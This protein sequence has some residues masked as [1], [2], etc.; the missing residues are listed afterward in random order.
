MAFCFGAERIECQ[1]S[2]TALLSE[3]R[4]GDII[5]G[6]PR[7]R[8][9]SMPSLGCSSTTSVGKQHS[10]SD[11]HTR[12]TFTAASLP[13]VRGEMSVWP[14]CH[15]GQGRA[16][17]AASASVAPGTSLGSSKRLLSH[18]VLSTTQKGQD[19]IKTGTGNFCSTHLPSVVC[20]QI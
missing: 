3:E 1:H 4:G 12:E 7:V 13:G 16:T 14:A 19:K 17:S 8:S 20:K 6:F 9:C 10:A 11:R 15:H 5:T 2:Q 18:P